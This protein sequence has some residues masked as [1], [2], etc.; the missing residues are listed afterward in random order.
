MARCV[1]F[2]AVGS[3]GGVRAEDLLEA[4]EGRTADARPA[5]LCPPPQSTIMKQM[6]LLYG[7][8]F[9]EEERRAL[10]P[11]C[12]SLA[13][14]AMRVLVREAEGCDEAAAA[15][16]QQAAPPTPRARQPP[17]PPRARRASA[18][19]SAGAGAG[20][21]PEAWTPPLSDRAAVCAAGAALDEGTA[22]AIARLWQRDSGVAAA[23]ARVRSSLADSAAYFLDSVEALAAPGYLPSDE[24]VL[25]ARVRTTGIAEE[26]FSIEGTELVVLDVGGQRNERRKWIDAFD[27]VAAV[28]FVAALSDYDQA[29]VEDAAANRM[30]EAVALWSEICNAP[31]FADAAML[32]LLNKADLFVEKLAAG[33]DIRDDA[34][35]IPRFLDYRGGCDAR[36][37]LAY[38]SERFTEHN[39]RTDAASCK[40]HVTCATD[41][42]AMRVVFDAVTDSLLRRNL[43][44]L[45][46]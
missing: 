14:D 11:V 40:L 3:H 33:V 2:G 19:S 46:L 9:S 23:F 18:G 8:G 24:D 45:D 39:R 29:L 31:F 32:L 34:G 16:A 27:G 22:A 12:G 21:V 44:T 1:L 13:L 20:A 37:A 30:V 15:C 7:G 4:R 5:L 26:I 6:R 25:R 36:R 28:I 17:A 38:L 42:T 10:A 35:A 41:T 43:A